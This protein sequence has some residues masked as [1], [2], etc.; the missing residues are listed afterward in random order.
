[1]PPERAHLTLA[2]SALSALLALAACNAPTETLPPG[3]P[4]DGGT[5]GFP[6][7]D[8]LGVDLDVQADALQGRLDGELLV[9]VRAGEP[10]RAVP[11][12]GVLVRVRRGE[13]D[14]TDPASFSLPQDAS[15]SISG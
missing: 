15:L 11:L 14:P 5:T 8:E 1:M 3:G 6:S 2:R 12:P 4:A 9:L 7:C 10:S 13:L